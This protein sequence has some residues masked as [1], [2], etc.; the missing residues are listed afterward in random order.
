VIPILQ[1]VSWQRSPLSGADP[2]RLTVLPVVRSLSLYVSTLCT[3]VA[4]GCAN[5]E[6]D[7]CRGTRVVTWLTGAAKP[8]MSRG[9]FHRSM[10]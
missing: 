9:L 7:L 6:W 4:P 1:I 8:V 3:W 10:K 5:P 2:G